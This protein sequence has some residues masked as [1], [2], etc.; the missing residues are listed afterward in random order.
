MPTLGWWEQSF[1]ANRDGRPGNEF[2]ERSCTKR[3]LRS[4]TVPF[5]E[6]RNIQSVPSLGVGI[7]SGSPFVIAP[8]RVKL[9]VTYHG[10]EA[11]C[12]VHSDSWSMAQERR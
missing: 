5:A 1:A 7:S 3:V 6:W 4:R 8:S 12:A 2:Y 9:G 11:T 10:V